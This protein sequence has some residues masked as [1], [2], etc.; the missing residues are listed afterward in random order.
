M[1]DKDMRVNVDDPMQSDIFK[2]LKSVRLET[3][4]ITSIMLG[5]LYN[6]RKSISFKIS[7]F[8]SIPHKSL[9]FDVDHCNSKR[10]VFKHKKYTELIYTVK[11]VK[12]VKFPKQILHLWCYVTKINLD[13]YQSNPFQIYSGEKMLLKC[14]VCVLKSTF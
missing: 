5:V 11:R 7:F 1:L 3:S 2:L 8:V 14:V 12:C 13:F 10:I 4:N 6:C 9:K